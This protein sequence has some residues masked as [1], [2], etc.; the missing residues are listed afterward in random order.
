MRKATSMME[1]IFVIVVIGIIASIAVPRLNATR[2]DATIATAASNTNYYWRYVVSAF[3][4]SGVQT[5]NARN[6]KKIFLDAI[7]QTATGT[8]YHKEIFKR[9]DGTINN[10]VC[11][12]GLGIFDLKGN[13]CMRITTNV[14]DRTSIKLKHYRAKTDWC[15]RVQRL[16][17]ERH[18]KINGQTEFSTSNFKFD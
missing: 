14:R 10:Q 7:A 5:F 3:T 4:A 9:A 12:C 17:P 1:L 15:K 13:M 18:M 16:V 11:V 2:N 6:S 8:T